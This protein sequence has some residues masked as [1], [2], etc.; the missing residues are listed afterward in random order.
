MGDTGHQHD[1]LCGG[2]YLLSGLLLRHVAICARHGS[3][4]DERR[5]TVNDSSDSHG[6]LLKPAKLNTAVAVELVDVNKWYGDFHVLRDINL[7]V[8]GKERIVICVPSRS[9]KSTMSGCLNRLEEH[10]AR[11]IVID[12]V[13]LTAGL[14]KID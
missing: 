8:L 3:A 5:S 4:A 6:S 11:H 13:E 14:E 2:C 9:G 7:K 10:Q 1:G 12:C